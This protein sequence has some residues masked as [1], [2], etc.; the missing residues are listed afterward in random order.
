MTPGFRGLCFHPEL[1]S[2]IRARAKGGDILLGTWKG[3]SPP[4][5]SIV[6][7]TDFGQS[8]E[9]NCSACEVAASVWLWAKVSIFLQ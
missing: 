4:P 8:A 2:H 9:R 7:F 5:C 1:S 6:I 3:M